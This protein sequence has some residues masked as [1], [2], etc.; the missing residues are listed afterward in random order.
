MYYLLLFERE[1]LLRD[2]ITDSYD[3]SSLGISIF[4]K[5]K[6]RRNSTLTF[7]ED[8][9]NMFWKLHVKRWIIW[10]SNLNMILSER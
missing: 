9:K 6:I 5:I 3:I 10:K 4:K 7:K 8:L 2:F 1:I